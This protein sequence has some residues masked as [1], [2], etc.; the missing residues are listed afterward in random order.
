MEE[1]KTVIIGARTTSA[2]RLL[3]KAVAAMDGK[4]VS[5]WIHEQVVEKAVQRLRAAEAE[6]PDGDLRAQDGYA[7]SARD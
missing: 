4:T 5:Q 2:N 7:V 1:L 6:V 3:V